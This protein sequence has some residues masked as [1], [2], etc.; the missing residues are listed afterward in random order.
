MLLPNEVISHIL[1]AKCQ[2]ARAGV[3]YHALEKGPASQHKNPATSG[4]PSR[5]AHSIDTPHIGP[6][7]SFA[8]MHATSQI[9]P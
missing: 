2:L 6:A 9:K 1:T 4:R 8:D 5:S 3:V 7:T